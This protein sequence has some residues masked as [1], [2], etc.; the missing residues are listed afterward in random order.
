MY[1]VFFFFFCLIKSFPKQRMCGTQPR[2][3]CQTQPITLRS[4]Y[5]TQTHTEHFL[6]ERGC[7]RTRCQIMG[8]TLMLLTHAFFLLDCGQSVNCC[9]FYQKA[10]CS[11][12]VYPPLLTTLQTMTSNSGWGSM[13]TCSRILVQILAWLKDSHV[14][15]RKKNIWLVKSLTWC[16]KFACSL[17]LG[18]K[19]IGHWWGWFMMKFAHHWYYFSYLFNYWSACCNAIYI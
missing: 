19:D 15:W 3:L 9:W 8:P 6:Q 10:L 12:C 7:E 4:A 13:C 5:N 2:A 18:I 14:G 17:L 16:C 11:H 1:G